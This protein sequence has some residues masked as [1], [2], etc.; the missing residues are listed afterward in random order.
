MMLASI[1]LKAYGVVLL[2]LSPAAAAACWVVAL[3]PDALWAGRRMR[4]HATPR[5]ACALDVL[6]V[7]AGCVLI[8][9]A[10]NAL[11][12]YAAMR[13][14]D[15][16]PLAAQAA[17]L[18]MRVLQLPAS[19][20]EGQVHL[21]T[22][23]GPLQLPVDLDRLGIML[24]LLV[25]GFA[26]VYVLA[27]VPRW[28]G[29]ARAVGWLAAVLLG[30]MLLRWVLAAGLFL[31]LCDFVGYE[32]EELP[33][34]PFLKPGMS[35]ALYLPFL[36][37]GA[38]VLQRRFRRLID[39][40]QHQG[41]AAP[42]SAQRWPWLGVLLLLTAVLWEPAGEPKTGPV[43]INTF[44]THWS[45]T[46][47]PYD[48]EWYGSGAGYNYACL[49]RFYGE[50]HDV[51]ELK[52]RI[53][54]DDLKDASVLIVYVPDVAFTEAEQQAVQAF[55]RRGGGLFLI[56][57]HTNV[58]GSTS[59]LNPLARPLGFIFR[60]DVMFDLDEDFFQ[61]Y[62]LPRLQSQFLHGIPFFKF[63]GPASIEPTSWAT[64]TTFRLGNAKSL[65]SIYSVNNFYPPPHD[66]PKM[67]TGDFAAAV[68]ARYGRGRVVAFADSTIFS[69]FEIFYP[70]KYEYLLN[71]VRWLNRADAPLATPLKRIG[72]CGL[73]LLLAWLLWKA[74]RPRRVLGAVLTLVVAAIA[75]VAVCNVVERTRAE[76]PH[77]T[78]PMQCLFFAADPTDEAYTLRQFT[79][80]KSFEQKFDVFIQWVL[81]SDIYSGFYLCGPEYENELYETLSA[82]DQVDMGLGLIVKSPEHLELLTGLGPGVLSSADRLLLMFSRSLS[83]KDVEAA[84]GE[85][86]VLP[87]PAMLSQVAAAWPEGEVRLEHGA[88]R[89]AVVFPAERYSD[90]EMGFSEKVDPNDAQR[91]RYAE[92]FALMDWL[93]ERP[94]DTTAPAAQAPPEPEE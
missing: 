60:D 32:T 80:D 26:L 31:F 52:K 19:A 87:E 18:L 67:R 38:V 85:A 84:L 89:I 94:A 69:N 62:D 34:A 90:R 35:A 93:F 15:G 21:T 54:P 7:N 46:D 92:Q 1:L 75:S 72:A 58:L 28:P 10:L 3:V 13:W 76:F 6:L 79:T 41:P 81:R 11:A 83:W 66:D 20:F 9:L 82:S 56:G 12:V 57:D 64:R 33:I 42:A 50:F 55:V 86:K 73:V 45:R 16:L 17:A 24:P 2:G 70:G 5:S 48:R 53:T 49:K 22:M 37:A 43:L 23:A 25:G 8:G 40:G 29:V 30:A 71:V 91:A 88:R 68:S 63:R 14:K 36:L 59:H 4:G 44:H 39:E 51:R 47:R 27:A 77:P 74:R 65:R 61:L 78:R